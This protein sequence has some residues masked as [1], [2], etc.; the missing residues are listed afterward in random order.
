[1]V[2]V[3]V[4]V[5]IME[6]VQVCR[7]VEAAM[8]VVVVVRLSQTNN[9]QPTFRIPPGTMLRMDIVQSHGQEQDVFLH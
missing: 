1:M 5:D 4:V 8:V 3:V 2:Q 7:E 9:L 6:V